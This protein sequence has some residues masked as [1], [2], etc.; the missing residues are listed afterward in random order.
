MKITKAIIPVAGWG[1]R[2]LPITKAIEK[3][4]LPIGNRP[5]VDYVV[6]DC[7]QAGITDI[8]FVVSDWMTQIQTYYGENGVL[9]TYL[10][11][12]NKE[13]MLPLVRPPRDVSFHFVTQDTNGKYGTAIPVSLVL[14]HLQQGESAVLLMGDD[15]IYNADGSSEV[16]RLLDATPEGGN[17]MLGASVPREMVSHYGVIDMNERSEFTRIVEKPA[18]EEAPSTLINISKYVFNYDLL[19]TISQYSELALTGE[20]YITE[21][22]NQYVTNGGS[23]VV[24]PAQGQYLDGGSVGGWLHAN[25]VVYAAEHQAR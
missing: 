25:N 14:P 10:I 19:K 16:R 6:Q 18:P 4:M 24:A 17:A 9:D 20:Y 7:I 3:C 11:G 5:I 15:F 8:Y 13:D 1:T 23:V 12:N 22:I 2:R 21:P